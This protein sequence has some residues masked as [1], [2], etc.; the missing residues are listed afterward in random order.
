MGAATSGKFLPCCTVR[1]GGPS[2]LAATV[3]ACAIHDDRK[4][5]ATPS[6]TIIRS[7]NRWRHC[8]AAACTIATDVIDRGRR[9]RNADAAAGP[10]CCA[11]STSF[12]PACRP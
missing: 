4:K 7:A 6:L 2:R 5:V 11:I 1:V 10:Q 3:S 8:S 12:H 9:V